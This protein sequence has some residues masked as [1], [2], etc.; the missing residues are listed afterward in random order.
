METYNKIMRFFWL[1]MAIVTFIIVTYS[2]IFDDYKTW[3][4][5][6]IFPVIA[7]IM[8]WMKTWM[9]KRMQKHQ[10]FLEDKQNGES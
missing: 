2:C 1:G 3:I 8:Y 10:Q 5:Y 7:F 9:M 6:Y 4:F